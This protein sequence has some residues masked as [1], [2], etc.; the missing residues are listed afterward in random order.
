MLKGKTA[1]VTGGGRGIGKAVAATFV[2]EGAKVVISGRSADAL[3]A[4]AKEIGGDVECIAA[5]LSVLAEA[6][7]LAADVAARYGGVDVL[8]NNAG[9][10]AKG[11]GEAGEPAEFQTMMNLNVVAPMTLTR[12]LT[13]KMIAQKEGVVINMGS[14]AAVESMSGEAAAYAASKHALRGWSNSIYTSLRHHNI[15]TLLVNPAFVATDMATA[16]P[17]VIPDRMIQPG[18]IGE[19]CLLPFRMTSGACPQEVTVRL[20]LS[21]YKE[22]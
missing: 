7:K 10:Y 3:A 21:A 13:A 14:V 6:E 22:A 4:A 12:R 20:T 16:S 11:N 2:K 17:N 8:V 1:L 18:D 9:M 15:K 19:V 5:D